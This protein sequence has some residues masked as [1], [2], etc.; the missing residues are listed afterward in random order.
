MPTRRMLRWLA[1]FES[2]KETSPNVDTKISGVLNFDKYFEILLDT[3]F[4]NSFGPTFTSR[5]S[6]FSYTMLYYM[7]C[8]MSRNNM[9]IITE[10]ELTKTNNETIEQD[11]L[12]KTISTVFK[13]LYSDFNISSFPSEFGEYYINYD[14]LQDNVKQYILNCKRFLENK[15]NENDGNGHVWNSN[16]SDLNY[17]NKGKFIDTNNFNQDLSEIVEYKWVPLKINGIVKNYLTPYIGEMS[18]PSNLDKEI[19]LNYASENFPSEVQRKN[20]IEDLNTIYKSLNDIQKTT[21]EVF[22]GGSGTVSPPGQMNIITYYVLNSLNMKDQMFLHFYLL[23]TILYSSAIVTWKIKR[24]YMQSRPL[25]DIRQGI[26]DKLHQIYLSHSFYD[27]QDEPK[28]YNKEEYT[29][30]QKDNFVTPPFPDF[31]SGHSCF[32]SSAMNFI[33]ELTNGLQP[34][35]IDFIPFSLKHKRYFCPMLAYSLD[36]SDVST[37]N[38]KNKT[39]SINNEIPNCNVSLIYNYWDDIS[40]ASGMSRLYGGIHTMTANIVGLQLGKMISNDVL[41]SKNIII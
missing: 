13:K 38:V 26:N 3:I 12:D 36:N 17:E 4:N 9:N 28:K 24:T 34:S 25:Q 21:A 7:E 41:K 27:N 32:T 39:S 22:E 6:Y 16:A 8:I 14:N 23:N 15:K 1:T 19:Y 29:P 40:N 5:F 31:T 18:L 37:F 10:Q 30:Y 2:K 11:V 20:E 33:Q 35:D